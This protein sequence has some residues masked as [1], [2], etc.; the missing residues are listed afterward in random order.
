MSSSYPELPPDGDLSYSPPPT[1]RKLRFG[2]FEVD[3]QERELRNRGIR[4]KLQHKPFRILELLLQRPGVLVTRDQLARHLW[5]NVNVSVD[6]GLNTAVNTLR[7]VLGDSPRRCRYIETRSGLG[8]RFI[9]HIE[10]IEDV[11]P[12]PQGHGTTDSIA[13]LPFENVT[14]D[15]AMSL[16]SDGLAESII[17][18]LSTLQHVRVIART[19]AFRFRPPA[20]EPQH[21]GKQLNVRSVLIGHVAQS[22]ASLSHYGRAR[23]GRNRPPLMGRAL[24]LRP[25]PNLR[26]RKRYSARAL[27][28]TSLTLRAANHRRRLTKTYTA[29]FDAYQDYLRGRYFYDRMSEDDLRKSIAHFEAALPRIPAMPSHTPA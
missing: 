6:R 24:Q 23:R 5:P 7:H 14:G 20:N 27:E 25:R 10:E 29:N 17:A 1:A 13:V 16:V 28:N 4:V 12:D 9:A 2:T 26:R 18:N 8:Y 11:Q 15:P 3:L 19:T 21:A 22:G